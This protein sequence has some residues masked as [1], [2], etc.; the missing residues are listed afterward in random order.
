MIIDQEDI[1]YEDDIVSKDGID[2]EDDLWG[3]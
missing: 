3:N 1:E 2:D